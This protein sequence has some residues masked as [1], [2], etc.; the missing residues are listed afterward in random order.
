MHVV[1][2]VPVPF[3]ALYPHVTCAPSMDAALGETD[4]YAGEQARCNGLLSRAEP[5]GCG[6]GH[7]PPLPVRS[8]GGERRMDAMSGTSR[9]ACSDQPGPCC[10][11]LA[12]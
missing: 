6:G 10:G 3:D 2:L 1:L 4:R 7:P 8:G 11:P 5:P 12:A 9:A